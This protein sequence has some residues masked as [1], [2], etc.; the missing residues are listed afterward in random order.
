[1]KVEKICLNPYIDA[2]GALKYTV[3]YRIG[4]RWINESSISPDDEIFCIKSEAELLDEAKKNEI[5]RQKERIN[6]AIQSMLDKKAQEYR[7]DSI[8]SARSYAGFDNPFKNEAL[9]LSTWAASCWAKAG[10][11]EADVLASNRPMPTIEE[12]LAEMPTFIP[13]Q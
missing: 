5:N 10:E 1:M 7:Y 3:R 9:A 2:D 4:T 13:P 12:I 8:L 11:I 6:K